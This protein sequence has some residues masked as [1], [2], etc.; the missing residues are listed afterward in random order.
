MLKI[1]VMGLGN[2]AQKAYLPVMAAMQDDY[3]WHLCTRNAAKGQHLAAKYGFTHV[4]QTL[5][6][7]I[8]SGVDA[9]FV[10]TPT[11]THAA[12]IEQLLQA[13]VNVYVDKPVAT[14]PDVVARLYA[15]AEEKHLL[16]TCG[17]NRRFAPNNVLLKQVAGKQMV[18]AEKS[19]QHTQQDAEFALWDLMIHPLDTALWLASEP[20]MPT[21]LQVRTDTAGMLQQ[22][23]YVADGEHVHV[24]VTVNMDAHANLEQVTVQGVDERLSSEDLL[25]LRRDD[26]ASSTLVHRPDWEPVLETRGF[27]P[28]I[29]A[30]LQAVQNSG[31]NPVS[32]ESVL[33]SHWACA[34]L[35]AE[36]TK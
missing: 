22:A 24:A 15:L 6:E 9:V 1:G 4:C 17:F 23:Y 8:A 29:R 3:E 21:A 7:L 10:H 31:T 36:L 32:P 11:A 30:F 19:R 13:R 5:D 35:V 18:T 26:T 25:Q 2:I 34:A 12:I 20:V 27:A 14:D 33:A 16:L 28:L